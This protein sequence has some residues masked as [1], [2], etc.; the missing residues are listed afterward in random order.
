MNHGGF[1]FESR[2]STRWYTRC[3]RQCARR[4][5]RLAQDNEWDRFGDQLDDRVR[6]LGTG[7]LRRHGY[8]GHV[9]K[10]QLT[11][12]RLNKED[13][14]RIDDGDGLAPDVVLLR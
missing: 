1:K 5:T 9:D 4:C 3:T 12:D 6:G 10:F 11:G 14:I 8:V 2:R 13:P 7:C